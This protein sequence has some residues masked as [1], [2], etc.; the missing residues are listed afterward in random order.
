MPAAIAPQFQQSA[1]S[2]LARLLDAQPSP[3]FDLRTW[4]SSTTKPPFTSNHRG[5]EDAWSLPPITDADLKLVCWAVDHWTDTGR[6]LVAGLLMH[7][8]GIRTFDLAEFVG[9]SGS[10]S[11]AFRHVAGRLRAIERA[12]FWCGDAASKG[13]PRGQRLWID[14]DAEPSQVVR[15]VFDARYRELLD[16][17]IC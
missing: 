14:P 15:T 7:P 10:I 9:Y 11:S 6:Q 2:L 8:H 16:G 1:A 17:S 13:H 12:P 4:D 3:D 5:D